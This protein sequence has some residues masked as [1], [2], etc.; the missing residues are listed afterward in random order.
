[1]LSFRGDSEDQ[2]A[3]NHL[4]NPNPR[5]GQR[6]SGGTDLPTYKENRGACF[7]FEKTRSGPSFASRSFE[8]GFHAPEA[9][10]ISGK[11]KPEAFFCT[12][13]KARDEEKDRLTPYNWQQNK[14]INFH[15]FAPSRSL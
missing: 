7:T 6:F 8:N 12:R 9:H 4:G 5:N 1:M 15:N 11:E 14:I 10:E 2:K 13:Q 3:E